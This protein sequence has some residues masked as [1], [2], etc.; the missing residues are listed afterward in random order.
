MR[1]LHEHPTVKQFFARPH[2]QTESRPSPKLE[3]NR[4][5]Q[6][7]FESGVDDG[8]FREIDRPEGTASCKPM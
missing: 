6:L 7:C 1:L 8:G 3:A 2:I 5:R 4:L